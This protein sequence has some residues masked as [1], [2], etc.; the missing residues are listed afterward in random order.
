MEGEPK[1]VAPVLILTSPRLAG[2]LF[3]QRP[4]LRMIVFK[5]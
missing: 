1:E 4:V 2:L 3:P 5:L